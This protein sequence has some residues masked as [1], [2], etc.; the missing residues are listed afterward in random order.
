MTIWESTHYLP[1]MGIALTRE[2]WQKIHGCREYFC[3]YDDYN[4]DWTLTY[5]AKQCLKAELTVLVV[6]APRVFHMGEW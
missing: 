3:H 5:I 6:K 2:L 1:N 4:W